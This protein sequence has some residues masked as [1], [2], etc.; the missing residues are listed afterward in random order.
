MIGPQLLPLPTVP[1]AEGQSR[2]E[3]APLRQTPMPQN[4]LRNTSAAAQTPPIRRHCP[5]PHPPSRCQ[6]DAA[7]LFDDW[8]RW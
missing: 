7:L 2:M 4:P 1:M 6:R 8:L 3:S 5:R